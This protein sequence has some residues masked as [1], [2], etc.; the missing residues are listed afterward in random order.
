MLTIAINSHFE[1]LEMDIRRELE[2]QAGRGA[3]VLVLASLGSNS[4]FAFLVCSQTAVAEKGWETAKSFEWNPLCLMRS[5][6]MQM[7]PL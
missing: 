2:V 5:K 1:K 3:W 6:N 7:E 4:S